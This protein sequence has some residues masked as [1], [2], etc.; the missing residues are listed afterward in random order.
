MQ[1]NCPSAK[2]KLLQTDFFEFGRRKFVDSFKLDCDVVS[3]YHAN[4]LSTVFLSASQKNEKKLFNGKKALKVPK[5]DYYNEKIK[6]IFSLNKK[7]KN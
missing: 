6:S 7:G 5:K 4:R 3:R 2:L 1:K